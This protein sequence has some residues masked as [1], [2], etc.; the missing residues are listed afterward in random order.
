MPP[1][2]KAVVEIK[3]KILD[4]K[5]T[6]RIEIKE[7]LSTSIGKSNATTSRTTFEAVSRNNFSELI[8]ASPYTQ[9]AGQKEDKAQL[10]IKGLMLEKL[11]RKSVL[12]CDL[13]KEIVPDSN[14]N[15]LPKSKSLLM[16]ERI[17]AVLGLRLPH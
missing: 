9:I 16:T 8:A 14:P 10:R 4:A 7:T 5:Q 3:N 11:K 15:G 2:Y 13:F 1:D 12:N 17:S 6:E